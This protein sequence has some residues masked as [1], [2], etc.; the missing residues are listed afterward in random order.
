MEIGK[1]IESILN[2]ANRSNIQSAYQSNRDVCACGR[3]I[4]PIVF[5]TV[6]RWPAKCELCRQKDKQ[7]RE[8]RERLE[9]RREWRIRKARQLWQ[10]LRNVIPPLFEDVHLRKVNPALRRLMLSLPSDK[11]LFL[12]GPPG[13][14]KTFA[15]CALARFFIC[16][17]L[18][19][20][21][22]VF[23]D[24]LLS[25]RSC[26]SKNSNEGELIKKYRQCDKLFI[27]DLGT[28]V[29]IGVQETD[30]SLRTLYLILDWRIEN[31]KATFITSNKSLNEMR[32]S[33]DSRIADRIKQACQIMPVKG[34]NKRFSD[35][36][37]V[38]ALPA[39]E[40]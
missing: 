5:G 29:G 24:L 22:V 33:F 18:K 20:E 9:Q 34:P 21:R 32:V 11:G 36:R 13:I 10:A 14:G 37:Q 1:S 4:E 38:K 39:V 30:F 25:V 27:E 28:T 15:M 7:A 12:F 26:Y 2:T 35:S 6:C 3:R 16:K 40:L 19:V 8:L 17:G 31:C 23:E